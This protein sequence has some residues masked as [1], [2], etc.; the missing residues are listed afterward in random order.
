MLAYVAGLLALRKLMALPAQ[1]VA[2]AHA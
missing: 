1:G 2:N